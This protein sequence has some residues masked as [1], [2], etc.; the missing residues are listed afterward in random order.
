MK[1][2]DKFKSKY[3]DFDVFMFVFGIIL[4][5]FCLILIGMMFFAI[6]SSFNEKLM[7]DR[8]P[9]KLFASFN[10]KNYSDVF[11][12]MQVKRYIDGGQVYIKA[13]QMYL[14]SVLFSLGS[15]L[16]S[17][18]VMCTTAY[19]CAKYKN[20]I[21]KIVTNIV[22]IT[23]IVPIIGN[24]PSVLNVMIKLGFYNTIW[25]MFIQQSTFL[26]GAYFLLFFA[27]FN[28]IPNDFG[29]AAQIDGA[30]QFYT[31][32]R[33]YLPLARNIFFTMILIKF[34]GYW[35]D[36]QLPLLFMPDKPTIAFGLY[37][38]TQTPDNRYNGNMPLFLAA[39]V[40]VSLPIVL[41]F[42]IFHNKLLGNL[43][44]AE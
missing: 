16:T 15:A 22:I 14:N 26:G 10:V 28:S 33:I 5:L 38:L 29:E 43:S 30:S 11:L 9:L 20:K 40:L 44:A 42:C 19:M 39:A 21:S 4:T 2:K 12:Y 6:A 18:V 36:Y 27:S 8:Y 37:Y 13:P 34:I 23:M 7:F 17:T 41:L 25:G 1:L 32:V 3:P 24:T 35:N 31:Y